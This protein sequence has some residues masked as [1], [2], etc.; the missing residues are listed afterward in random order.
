MYLALYIPRVG[1]ELGII[2]S[3]NVILYF[4]VVVLLVEVEGG[5][6]IH[7]TEIDIKIFQLTCLRKRV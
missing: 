4:K 3:E 2:L 6:Y 1:K 5:L 7:T